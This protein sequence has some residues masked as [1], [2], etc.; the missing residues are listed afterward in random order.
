[1]LL[2]SRANIAGLNM[3]DLLTEEVFEIL[4]KAKES[5]KKGDL[6]EARRLAL[7]AVRQAPDHEEPWL[8]LASVSSPKASISYLKKALAVNP[9]S[10]QANFRFHHE[11]ART[12]VALTYSRTRTMIPVPFSVPSQHA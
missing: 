12:R 2:E 10:R 7:Q 3:T 11:Q 4:R 1:M 6:Q 8:Y 9:D 5:L